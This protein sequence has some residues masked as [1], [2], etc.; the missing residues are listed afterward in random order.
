[1]LTP[2]W[3]Y[4]IEAPFAASP[5]VYKGIV[6]LGSRDGVFRALNAYTGAE[7]WHHK[8][9]GWFDATPLV[10]SSTVYAISRDEQNIYAF[11][12]LTGNVQWQTNTGSNDCSSP[13]LYNNK[14]Y[15]LSGNPHN[16]LYCIDAIAGTLLNS[17]PIS[18]FG[19]SAPAQ[20]NN[21]LFF[22]T[23]D[24]MF[25]CFDMNA[26]A[27]IWSIP[28]KGNIYYTN[29]ACD[30]TSVYAL[31]GADE[32][33]LFCLNQQNGSVNWESVDIGSTTSSVSS[34]MLYNDK[35]Y[36]VSTNGSTTYFLDDNGNPVPI[37][38]LVLYAFSKNSSGQSVTPL[39]STPVGYVQKSSIVSSPVIADG[40][41]YVGSGD[42]CLYSLSADTNTAA[43]YYEPATGNLV[44]S[45][46]GY[47]LCDPA[48]GDTIG[49]GIIASPCVSNGWV[50]ASTYDGTAWGLKAKYSTA[51]NSP[52]NGDIVID[53]ATVNAT[54]TGNQGSTYSVSYSSGDNPT[55]WIFISSGTTEVNNQS[56]ASLNTTSL[57]NGKY[58]MSLT[59]ANAPAK[60]AINSF[61]VMNSPKLPQN[62][63]AFDTPHDAGNSITLTWTKSG[64][65]GAGNNSVTGYNIYK[66][67]TNVSFSFLT[68]V[69]SGTTVFVD[70]ACPNYV[71]F[72]YRLTAT[73]GLSE[74]A[75]LSSA[76][77]Y[78]LF[79][80]A[81][82]SASAGNFWNLTVL[83]STVP[84]AGVL[85]SSN[86]LSNDAWIGIQ[87]ST[88]APTS[89]PLSS[90]TV[91]INGYRE[92]T[93]NPSTTQLNNV[94][95]YIYFTPAD[96]AGI[97]DP[98]TL[99]LFHFNTSSG[100]WD[101]VRSSVNV[102]MGYVSGKA[103][104]FSYYAIMQYTP[105]YSGIVP[106]PPTNLTA[107]DTPNDAGG[108]VTL[109]WTKSPDD[110][111]WYNDV[112]GY[113]IYRSTDPALVYSSYYGYVSSGTSVYID[114]ACPISVTFYY[115][116][117]AY[118]YLLVESSFSNPSN[119]YSYP[120]GVPR[121]P[122]NLTAID[123]PNDAGGSISLSWTKSP[124]DG[125]GS[126]DAAG[127]NIYRSTDLNSLTSSLYTTI[128]SGTAVF[129]DTA[130][131]VYI[132]YYYSVTA[133]NNLRVNSLF[134]NTVNAFS[135]MDG[136]L[137]SASNGATLSLFVY[138]TTTTVVIPAQGLSNDA[139]IGIKIPQAF[140]DLSIPKSANATSEIRNFT[141]NP[142]TT[143]FL[144][145]VTIK[146][147]YAS[148]DVSGMKRENLRIYWA[149]TTNN[150]WKIVNT[151][152]S[153]QA[154][155]RVWAD[156]PHFSYYRIMEYMPGMEDLM[157]FDK[158]YTYPNPAT[159][160]SLYFKYYLG[161]NA[162]VTIDVYNIAGELIAHLSNP[163]SPA[164]LFSDIEW[165]ISG[166]ASGVYIY[167]IEAKS[168]SG[169][170]DIKK[171]LAIIH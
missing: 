78:A 88:I 152:L 44:S 84:V 101:M 131:P 99:K 125:Q 26:G 81:L 50:Y 40:T 76:S 31:S 159:G 77:A 32:R 35:V 56:I 3:S 120:N 43:Q 29:L 108:K 91:P 122:S 41:L 59:V 117:T 136:V 42:G 171:K 60:P 157:S 137:V 86:G 16:S 151:S 45:P 103:K 37:P 87:T 90:S 139:R 2:Q 73:D 166:I 74:S 153:E 55:S 140:T 23:C 163:N 123:T 93:I 168:A 4:Y 98:S 102:A 92:F 11:D 7:I 149:D 138:Q 47:M 114:S 105:Q 9:N 128:S 48:N 96:I 104:S 113:K 19:F 146:M 72:Y 107:F 70:T 167:R 130:C 94:T 154:E 25:D 141:I 64:D 33:H 97:A 112:A 46:T 135:E 83:G 162:D 6:Y 22:A 58:T 69:S 51:L 121:P 127:Y 144:Q 156:I 111:R 119:A 12:R 100:T 21:L 15:F 129:I 13:V 134:S 79:D 145:N 82:T 54:I 116:L 161:D 126:G 106:Y 143:T 8:S 68:E 67:S 14:L 27:N 5:V 170:K 30:T 62:L 118:N 133:I 17:Y 142:A 1:M 39:W 10:T 52:D 158:V 38:Q 85:I 49:I 95:I 24:G 160:K 63:S 20:N 36:F 80:G 124:D 66:S 150:V 169:A 61:T 53:S 110:G 57:P 165:N 75:P 147:P 89:V 115:A 109:S 132:V 71:N 155:L 65:D 148:G 18:K 34:V 28:T 164:G